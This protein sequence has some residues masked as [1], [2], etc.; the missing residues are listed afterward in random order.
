MIKSGFFD[1]EFIHGIYDREYS[2]E[3][4]SKCFK[5]FINDGIVGKDRDSSSYFETEIIPN[6]GN[7]LKVKPGFAWINGRWIESDSD[8]I[9]EVQGM[10]I[11]GTVRGDLICIR[12]D[13]VTREFTVVYKQ[14]TP[15]Q[16]GSEPI[17]PD[18]QD[19]EE[20][21]EMVIALVMIMHDVETID[22][23]LIGDYREFAK[24]RLYPDSSDYYTKSEINTR[25]GGLSFVKCT[26]TEYDNMSSHDENTVYII[27][28]G[29]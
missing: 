16:S 22:N 10:P 21:K 25:L 15:A 8:I 24:L 26:Q 12:C 13:Y 4:F 1:A 19:D 5:G 28:G 9:F 6:S 3:D 20:A 2:S 7:K 27:T 14:G 17:L 29:D 11:D 18:V 23:V